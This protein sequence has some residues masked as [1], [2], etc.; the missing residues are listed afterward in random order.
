MGAPMRDAAELA[1][2]AAEAAFTP[3]GEL[4]GPLEKPNWKVGPVAKPPYLGVAQRDFGSG[5]LQQTPQKSASFQ[6]L[7]SC[8]S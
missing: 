6:F 3:R 7:L 2:R 5:I 1:R 4:K 8:G